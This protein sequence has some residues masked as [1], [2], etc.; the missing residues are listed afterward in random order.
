MVVRALDKRSPVRR[1]KASPR[2]TEK[3]CYITSGGKQTNETRAEGSEIAGEAAR[4]WKIRGLL[5]DLLIHTWDYLR[6]KRG[7]K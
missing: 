3:T 6:G 7:R 5:V 4:S 2:L 1:K